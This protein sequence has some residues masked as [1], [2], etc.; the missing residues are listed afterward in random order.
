MTNVEFMS[1]SKKL[2][3]ILF[4]PENLKDKNPAILFVHGWT[5]VK[6]KS[7]QYAESL[8][9]LGFIVLLFD[10]RG[11]GESEGE[12]N[13]LKTQDF[14]DDDISAFDF[15][16]QQKGV[17]KENISAIGSS[18]G[19]YLVAL[20]TKERKIKNL[21]LRAP[22]DYP[23]DMYGVLKSQ[24]GGDDDKLMKWRRQV[25]SFND[26]FALKAVHNFEGNILIIESE[27]DDRVPHETVQCF[28]NAVSDKKKLTHK[29]V[30][31]APHS[32]KEGPFRDKVTKILI[33]WFKTS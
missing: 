2:K 4:Y 5:S 7:I 15:L 18:F 13:T 12:L 33:D 27:L 16:T 8:A 11:H 23:D 9:K 31:G 30:K 25:K 29:V 28:A 3:G 26:T 21:V 1:S 10:M 19:G 20:L 32:I 14:L 24:L 6:E 22:A 17:D